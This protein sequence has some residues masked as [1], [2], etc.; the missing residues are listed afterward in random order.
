MTEEK[1]LIVGVTGGIAAYKAADLVSRLV[2][3]GR[4]VQV[5]MTENAAR[6]VT[7]LTFATLS[8]RPVITSLWENPG[9]W[10]PEHVAL[11]QRAGLLAVVPATANFIGKYAGGIADDALT[12]TALTFRGPVVVAPAMNPDMW[13]SPA[14]RDNLATLRRR[15]TVIVDP[16]DGRVAC[17][18]PGVGRLAELDDILAAIAAH[19]VRA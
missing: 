7:P 2:K 16:A 6:L 9:E 17:G 14:V 5:V 12:T 15:G 10:R 1:L 8:R 13:A 4:Q 3:S 18:E 11:A 19:S